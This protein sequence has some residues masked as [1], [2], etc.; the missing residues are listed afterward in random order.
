[1]LFR[2]NDT[3]TTE[4][5][6]LSLH[7]A[8]PISLGALYWTLDVLTMPAFM[9]CPSI[10]AIDVSCC[11][12]EW[13]ESDEEW[14][15]HHV[16]LDRK[17]AIKRIHAECC[18]WDPE[19]MRRILEQTDNLQYFAYGHTDQFPYT[20]RLNPSAV[21]AAL[22]TVKKTLRLLSITSTGIRPILP[23]EEWIGTLSG[24]SQLRTV[25]LAAEIF[26]GNIDWGAW[27]LE[28]LLPP[29]ME[30]LHLI[31]KQKDWEALYPVCL[32][33]LNYGPLKYLK[34]SPTVLDEDHMVSYEEMCSLYVKGTEMGVVVK[35]Y[36]DPLRDL[37]AGWPN[38]YGENMVFNDDGSWTY[39]VQ[40]GDNVL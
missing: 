17:S 36:L 18:S 12:V 1:M 7:D 40:L 24:F 22:Q 20:D 9:A 25:E 15:N 13:D 35:I 6:T 10:E 28:D 29:S 27:A 21:G 32:D 26:L 39:G 4:I 16:V 14:F 30:S 38:L 31:C 8:L 3:A 2:S 19:G 33:I 34:V 37:G 5:Y 23:G 11:R